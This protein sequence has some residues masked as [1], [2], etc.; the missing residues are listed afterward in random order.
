MVQRLY[1][2]LWNR[3]WSSA[4]TLIALLVAVSVPVAA[5][6]D[7]STFAVVP[8]LGSSLEAVLVKMGSPLGIYLAG[9][10]GEFPDPRVTDAVMLT[11]ERRVLDRE[12]FIWVGLEDCRVQQVSLR[13]ADPIPVSELTSQLGLEPRYERRALIPGPDGLEADVGNEHDPQGDIQVLVYPSLGIEAFLDSQGRGVE[14]IELVAAASE[15]KV[16]SDDDPC[17][18]GPRR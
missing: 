11:Y 14:L 10:D 12:A 1:Q 4:A 3:S 13:F 17:D 5:W 16:L 18:R 7:I 15:G 6:T 8:P 9:E 2:P